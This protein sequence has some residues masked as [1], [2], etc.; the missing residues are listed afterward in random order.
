[1]A[2]SRPS[3]GSTW[4][5]TATSSPSRSPVSRR[6]L[7]GPSAFLLGEES[8]ASLINKRGTIKVRLKSGDCT[9]PSLAFDGT[10]ASGT[11]TWSMGATAGAYREATGSGGFT[12]TDANVAPGADNPGRLALTGA[13]NIHKPSLK[14][15][16][17]GTYWGFMG[18]DYALRRVTVIYKITNTGPG[19]AFGVMLKTATTPTKGATALGPVPQK[20]G[21]LLAGESETARIR[22]SLTVLQAQAIV[23]TTTVINASLEPCQL[24]IFNCKFR[25]VLGVEM[26]DALDRPTTYTGTVDATAPALP[27]PL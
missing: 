16:V 18:L 26:P 14:V 7:A 4:T 24:V 3:C 15:E 2:P 21:D 20:L 25:S 17:V 11:G 22:Y 9:N 12:L 23:G 5:C 10:K 6:Q 8:H 1:M 27:P 19:D 13:I